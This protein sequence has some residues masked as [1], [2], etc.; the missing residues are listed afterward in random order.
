M[1]GRR[2]PKASAAYKRRCPASRADM[3]HAKAAT[4]TNMMPS[5]STPTDS[6]M[7]PAAQ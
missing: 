4:S 5:Y 6:C 2:D 1:T 7:A 3:P